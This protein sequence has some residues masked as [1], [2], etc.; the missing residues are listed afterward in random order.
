MTRCAVTTGLLTV[1]I[2]FSGCSRAPAPKVVPK[3]DVAGTVLL[4]GNPMDVENGEI[5]LLPGGG[6]A[7]IILPIKGGKFEGKSPIGDVRIEVRA[8]RQGEPIMMDGKPFGE[9]QKVNVVSEV[10][11]D[12]SILK[13]T[14][15]AGGTKDLK[16]EVESKK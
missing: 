14:I 16:F 12:Q 8:W 6:E 2:L 5:S 1:M 4:D 10:Y 9:P 11:N 7:P 3:A 15:A 13:A